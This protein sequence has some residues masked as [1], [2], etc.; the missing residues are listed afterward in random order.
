MDVVSPQSQKKWHEFALLSKKVCGRQIPL[1]VPLAL[2][3]R[4]T[5]Q[6]QLDV[7]R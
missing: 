7:L 1:L 5:Q 3:G 6:H 4:D 2:D